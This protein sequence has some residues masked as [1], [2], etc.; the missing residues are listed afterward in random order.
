MEA[1]RGERGERGGNR[2]CLPFPIPTA[3]RTHTA[4]HTHTRACANTAHT[5]TPRERGRGGQEG[6]GGE[7]RRVRFGMRR[8]S[9][10]PLACKA[11]AHPRHASVEA[12]ERASGGRADTDALGFGAHHHH[13]IRQHCTRARQM[14]R[15]GE[16]H[17]RTPTHTHTRHTRSAGQGRLQAPSPH[18]ENRRHAPG[19]A[20]AV[21]NKDG[22]THM[23]SRPVADKEGARALGVKHAAKDD[24]KGNSLSPHG[25]L[26]S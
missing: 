17:T 25:P 24:Q 11:V 5:H 14:Q 16:R 8:G 20:G 6:R 21:P 4:I 2:I 23:L 12:S 13:H 1:A 26:F 18:E 3:I 19:E 22:A 15:H 10:R 9:Y 7:E